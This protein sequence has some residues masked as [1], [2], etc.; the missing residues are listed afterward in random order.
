MRKVAI[1]IAHC[2]GQDGVFCLSALRDRL[3]TEHD[4]KVMVDLKEVIAE[5]EGYQPAIS[6]V[7]VGSP[8]EPDPQMPGIGDRRAMGRNVNRS[9]RQQTVAACSHDPFLLKHAVIRH[10]APS[11]ASTLMTD[12]ASSVSFL[13]ASASSSNVS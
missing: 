2:L 8:S 3:G 4:A 10:Y 6:T 13:S 11:I 9:R 5:V 1:N 12:S 7:P